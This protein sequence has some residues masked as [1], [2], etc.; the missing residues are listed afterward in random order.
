MI[1]YTACPEIRLSLDIEYSGYQGYF[2]WR[3]VRILCRNQFGS[4]ANN[5]NALIFLEERIAFGYIF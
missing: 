4:L 3:R 1:K 5:A 2:R